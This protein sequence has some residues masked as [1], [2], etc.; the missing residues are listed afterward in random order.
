MKEQIIF[1]ILRAFKNDIE[2]IMK[3]LKELIGA[4]SPTKMSVGSP[5]PKKNK[6]KSKYKTLDRD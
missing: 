4:V 1:N 2:P 3:G 5:S 6:F